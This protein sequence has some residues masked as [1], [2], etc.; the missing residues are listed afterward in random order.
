VLFFEGEKCRSGS[1]ISYNWV[2]L[3]SS[4]TQKQTQHRSEWIGGISP[5][6]PSLFCSYLGHQLTW[7]STQN[8]K[9]TGDLSPSETSTHFSLST[10]LYWRF[11]LVCR[12]HQNP[13]KL[14]LSS[15]HQ[16]NKR[17]V[18]FLSVSVSWR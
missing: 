15:C 3:W 4:S 9:Y 10:N 1:K 12:V 2:L 16:W 17:P 5:V 18:S 14:F 6:K 11:N 13:L 7:S 8:M